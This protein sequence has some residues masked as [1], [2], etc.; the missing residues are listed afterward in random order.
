M[1]RPLDAL[2]RQI[3]RGHEQ[4][5][6]TPRAAP[7]STRRTAT[8]AGRRRSPTCS[9]AAR[10]CWSW[11]AGASR[12]PGAKAQDAGRQGRG[13]HGRHPPRREPRRGRGLERRGDREHQGDPGDA[14][15]HRLGRANDIE[16]IA[17]AM[18]RG[19]AATR[20]CIVDAVASLGCMPFEMDKWGVDVAMA[21]SQKGLMTPPGLAFTAAGPRA[22]D[23]HKKPE[24]AHALLGLDLPRRR[25]ALPEI[26]RHSAGAPA[27]RLAQRA[28][29]DLR[30]GAGE[31]ARAPRLLAEAT[32]RA[33]ATWAEGQAIGIN[34]TEP[35]G[36]LQLRSRP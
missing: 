30:R 36:A 7:T 24:H 12:S 14:D 3:A 16:A 26:R 17:K 13:A 25:S 28:R 15:R 22:R 10:R 27:V 8:A 2:T 4:A 35:G 29:H 21:G 9:R 23:A 18:R 20:S 31:C 11:K 34:C 1:R 19:R 6:S 32:R 33:V 5:S